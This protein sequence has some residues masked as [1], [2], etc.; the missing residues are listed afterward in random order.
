MMII[1]TMSSICNYIQH[2]IHCFL[3]VIKIGKIH[4]INNV[5]M[6]L[7]CSNVIQEWCQEFSNGGMTHPTGGLKYRLQGTI[8]VKNLQKMAF[9][10]LMGATIF[11]HGATAP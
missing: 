7:L 8:N 6:S 3:L 4:S 9:H 11:Q 2:K 10:L 1:I 5:G